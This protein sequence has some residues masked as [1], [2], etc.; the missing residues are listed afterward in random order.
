MTSWAVESLSGSPGA[1]GF[2]ACAATRS[3]ASGSPARWARWRSRARLR[4]CSRL[5]AAGSGGV[6]TAAFL[7]RCP[8]SACVGRKEGPC[9]RRASPGWARPFPRTGRGPDRA[10]AELRRSA[11]ARRSASSSASRRSRARSS[12]AE[13]RPARSHA[14]R[15]R[16][17]PSS[18][19]L[20]PSPAA[21]AARSASCSA[22]AAPRSKR[23]LGEQAR[24]ELAL[25]DAQLA[26]RRA[27]GAPR[28]REA[29]PRV[30]ERRRSSCGRRSG[31]R[32]ASG[33]R[34]PR[35][36]STRRR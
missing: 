7:P 25:E 9:V 32:R 16:R 35:G 33:T 22:I 12:S 15:P 24:L 6:V 30:R 18:R 27:A 13:R 36:R 34:R 14:Q 8:E 3:R 20:P 21:C 1:G 4:S 29:V 2:G 28:L 31:G 11:R 19:G 10:A 5:G 26:G 17:V 23:V